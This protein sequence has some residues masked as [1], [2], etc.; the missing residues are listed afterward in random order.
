[1]VLNRDRRDVPKGLVERAREVTPGSDTTV[2]VHDQL[3]E[4]DLF[5]S[6]RDGFDGGALLGDEENA[7]AP[8]YERSDQVGYG[9]RLARPGRSLDDEG[10]TAEYPVDRHML[11]GVGIKYQELLCGRIDVGPVGIGITDPGRQR[12]PR[13][14][15][16][17]DCGD[18]VVCREQRTVLLEV[19]YQRHRGVREDGCN[20]AGLDGQFGKRLPGLLQPPEQG[21]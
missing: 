16:T 15:V 8:R 17:G 3:A 20:N 18:Y 14:A 5:Q 7:L 2:H 13:L 21:L 11:T 9:L 1:M 19:A 6:L 10:L 12:L 4:P